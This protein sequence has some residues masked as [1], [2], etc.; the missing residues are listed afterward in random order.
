MTV[1]L[2]WPDVEIDPPT[3]V[4]L[5]VSEDGVVIMTRDRAGTEATIRTLWS[6][7]IDELVRAMHDA[8]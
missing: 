8:G 3:I 6:P 7:E 4:S 2:P 1:R 5:T